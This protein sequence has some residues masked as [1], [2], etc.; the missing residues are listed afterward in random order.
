MLKKG[1]SGS[2]VNETIRRSCMFCSQMELVRW[3]CGTL[4]VRSCLLRLI[5]QFYS[6]SKQTLINIK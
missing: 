3:I 6:V 2:V 4:V 5:H 1:V